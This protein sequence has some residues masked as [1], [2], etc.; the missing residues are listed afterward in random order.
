MGGLDGHR[1]RYRCGRLHIVG[2]LGFTNRNIRLTMFARNYIEVLNEGESAFLILGFRRRGC[3][4]YHAS[5]HVT[6]AL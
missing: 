4:T 3:H 2:K 1:I 6:P 5:S